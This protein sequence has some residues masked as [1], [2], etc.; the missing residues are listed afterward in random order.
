MTTWI[1]IFCTLLIIF[2]LLKN[3]MA[4]ISYRKY[5]ENAIF[6]FDDTR[7]GHKIMRIIFCALLIFMV[8]CL[9]LT[10]TKVGYDFDTIMAEIC[11]I[12]A[13]CL[14][15]FVPYSQARWIVTEGGVFIY[16][17]N[18]FIPWSEMTSTKPAAAGKKSYL[19]IF[20]RGDDTNR[21]K[22][23]NYPIMLPGEKVTQ[24]QNMFREFISLEDKR[25]MK[26]RREA[27]RS[28]SQK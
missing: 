16:N 24:M 13:S 4:E 2:S 20:L 15:A 25:R 23:K 8:I 12:S 9:I 3:I 21:L 10:I 27:E 7:T 22:K 14:F 19:I 18:L 1:Y 28:S 6:I 17:Y 5:K 26:L 11:L